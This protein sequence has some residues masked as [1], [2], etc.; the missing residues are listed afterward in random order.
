MINAQDALSDDLFLNKFKN[1]TC[2]M[3]GIIFTA[4]YGRVFLDKAK[5]GSLA[6]T[7]WFNKTLLKVGTCKGTVTRL[8]NI[9]TLKDFLYIENW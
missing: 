5:D 2:T 6:I 1:K 4:I 7:I 3:N 8:D 9:I